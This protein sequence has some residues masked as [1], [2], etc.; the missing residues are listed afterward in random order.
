MKKI[1]YLG[2]L[3][4]TKSKIIFMIQL[5]LNLGNVCYHSVQNVPYY[6]LQPKNI[7]KN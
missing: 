6:S 4:K 7:K 2:N 3:K 1:E 5:R